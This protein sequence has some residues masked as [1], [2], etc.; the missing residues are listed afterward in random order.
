MRRSWTRG[1]TFIG[2]TG[3][4][5]ESQHSKQLHTTTFP[6]KSCQLKHCR[7]LQNSH[8]TRWPTY[9]LSRVRGGVK[10]DMDSSVGVG[11][12]ID[13]FRG[14]PL[15]DTRR[16]PRISTSVINRPRPSLTPPSSLRSAEHIVATGTGGCA[17]CVQLGA[18]SAIT[19]AVANA[20]QNSPSYSSPVS[21]SRYSP[22]RH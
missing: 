19:L 16:E 17:R 5:G 22:Q 13:V 7:Y 11:K 9:R 15:P 6:T 3:I 20:A 14:R 8:A 2:Q 10:V 1:R 12:N 4:L 18:R 21:V